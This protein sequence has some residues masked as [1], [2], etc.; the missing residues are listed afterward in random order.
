MIFTFLK[1]TYFWLSKARSLFG[2]DRSAFY[3]SRLRPLP[4]VLIF[5]IHVL[6]TKAEWRICKYIFISL[7]FQNDSCFV[8]HS[9]CY[10]Q[11]PWPTLMRFGF[12][13]YLYW[14]SEE[15]SSFRLECSAFLITMKFEIN[16]FST[17]AEQHKSKDFLISLLLPNGG[18][19]V[20]IFSQLG[21][22]SEAYCAQNYFKT[23]TNSLCLN[24]VSVFEWSHLP[25][26]SINLAYLWT[27][28]CLH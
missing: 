23:S 26:W 25:N 2:L 21:A 14:S 9:C 19:Y 28:H 24:V 4:I 1:L 7:L 6:C 15:R 18:C 3:T 13:T 10:S 27:M 11:T 22:T 17:K 8:N 5:G 12:I 20:G 16:I